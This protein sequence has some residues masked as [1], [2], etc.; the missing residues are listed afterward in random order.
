MS[1]RVA[2]IMIG[3]ILSIVAIAALTRIYPLIF[4][5]I[6][7]GLLTALVL[8]TLFG[9]LLAIAVNIE[10]HIWGDNKGD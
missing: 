10:T 6:G 9:I 1:K 8:W 2:S 7:L 3:I 5:W 4:V